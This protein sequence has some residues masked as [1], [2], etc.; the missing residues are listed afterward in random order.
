MDCAAD[1]SKTSPSSRILRLMQLLLIGLVSLRVHA[2]AVEL[3]SA[4]VMEQSIASNALE[5]AAAH[6]KAEHEHSNSSIALASKTSSEELLSAPYGYEDG[7]YFRAVYSGA[8]ENPL[9]VSNL[10]AYWIGRIYDFTSVGSAMANTQ[11]DNKAADYFGYFRPSSS[12]VWKFLFTTVD[13][14]GYFWFGSKALGGF[15]GTNW[16]AKGQ[17]GASNTYSSPSLTAGSIYPIRIHYADNGGSQRLNFQAISPS[18]SKFSNLDDLVFSCS[19]GTETSDLMH[20][21][22]FLILF[23][24]CRFPIHSKWLCGC[25]LCFKRPVLSPCSELR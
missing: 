5:S 16:N 12:G 13:D 3:T 6:T 24:W 20:V 10:P 18:G 14:D 23:S 21:F 15:S 19:N 8:S 2:S 22:V 7:L 9:T 17:T 1:S 25:A 11:G 4:S